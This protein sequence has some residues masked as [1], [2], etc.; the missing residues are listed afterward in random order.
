MSA[1]LALGVAA[2][3]ATGGGGIDFHDAR[4]CEI[5]E[6]RGAPPAARVL[7]WNTIGESRCPQAK[8]DAL[9]TAAI[10]RERGDTIVLRNGPRHFLMDSAS[11]TVGGK[12][13]FGG[14]RMTNVARIPVRTAEDLQRRLYAD[15]TIA[16]TN[17]WTWK[18]GRRIFELVAPGGDT[19]VM[20]SYA[21]I[22]DPALTLA[23]LPALG[24]RLD[25]PAGWRYRTRVLKRPLT[26]G[27]KGAAT[28]L[29]DD[30][31]DT[32]QLATTTRRGRPRA[33]TL[34]LKGATRTTKSAADGSVTDEGTLTGSLGRG[35]IVL[36]GRVA[37][38]RLT[39]TVRMRFA[40]GE[41]QATVDAPYTVADGAID[42]AGTAKVFDGTGRYRGITSGTLQVRDR[43]TLDGQH[44]SFAVSGPARF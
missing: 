32:Y 42:F 15:R 20:Q 38:G 4:Y 43:N 19:Y 30:L 6:V 28:V 18:Q 39:G 37:D 23:K 16:R 29:Q 22:V 10:A 44:G 14:L 1:A 25:P 11:A 17:T 21:L 27:A 26:L 40:D 33:R 8:W 5:F 31:Q 36:T 13:T 2:A 9:D 24:G 34:D 41:V 35:T 3:A 12:H 7:V